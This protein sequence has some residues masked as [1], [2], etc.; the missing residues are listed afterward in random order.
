MVATHI[1]NPRLLGSPLVFCISD[2]R[3]A[4]QAVAES[5]TPEP[6]TGPSPLAPPRGTCSPELAP[7]PSGLQLC[8]AAIGEENECERASLPKPASKTRTIETV[9][10]KTMQIKGCQLTVRDSTRVPK[11]EKPPATRAP[12]SRCSN[13]PRR[14]RTLESYLATQRGLFPYNP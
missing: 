2:R 1:V 12:H 14:R 9:R 3:K 8:E 11:E 7:P 5:R 4:Q 13:S 6:N 10:E